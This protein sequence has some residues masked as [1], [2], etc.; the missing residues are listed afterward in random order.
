[1]LLPLGL[2]LLRI[3]RAANAACGDP[4]GESNRR[5]TLANLAW[6]AFGCLLWAMILLGMATYVV[7]EEAW[8]V[9]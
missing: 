2:I 9:P 6:L 3:Q 1:M 4:A 8:A 5:L 7:P